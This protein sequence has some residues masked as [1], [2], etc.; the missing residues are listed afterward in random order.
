VAP[1]DASGSVVAPTPRNNSVVSYTWDFGDGGSGSGMTATH[2]CAQAGSYTLKLS[3][4]DKAGRVGTATETVVVET[5]DGDNSG[6]T[7]PVNVT[8]RGADGA[9]L[10]GA[11]V[12]M[13]TATGTTGTAGVAQFAQAPAGNDQVLSVSKAGFITQVL[14]VDLVAGTTPQDIGVRLLAV[15]QTIAIQQAEQAQVLLANSLGASVSV[16]A[17]ALVNAAGAVVT[18][19]I[20]LQLTPWD[21]SGT[22]LLAMP[23]NGQALDRQNNPAEL[24][25]AGM[26]T[27]DFR[28]AGGNK[29]QLGAGKTAD[30]QMDLPYASVNRQ[31]LTIGTPI[32]LWF[33]DESKGLWVEDGQGVVVASNTSPVGLGFKATVSHFST[34]NWDFKFDN[35]GSVTVN[36]VNADT[37]TTACAV[38]ATVTL[39]DGSKLVKSNTLGAT[40]TTV[41]N[42]PSDGSIV[43]ESSTSTGL[44]GT[45][46]SGTSGNVVIT[47]NPPNTGNFVQC[48]LPGNTPV[49]CNVSL[50]GVRPDG[51]ET[52]QTF[53][54]PAEGGTVQT[55]LQA[56]APLSWEG[57]SFRVNADLST[58]R[59]RG[60]ATSAA[61]GPVSIAL[62]PDETVATRVARV[63]C[64]TLATVGFNQTEPLGACDITVRVY[65]NFEQQVYANSLTVAT[66]ASVH[67]PVADGA[68]VSVEAQGVTTGQQRVFSFDS[69]SYDSI[70]NNALYLLRLTRLLD[71]S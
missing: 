53:A 31:A 37:T 49:A 56:T 16:P 52:T 43:W 23:G 3:V 14:S 62:G 2:T 38:V 27:V 67:V 33:F 66:G 35:A 71:V 64:D 21:I 63:Q 54:L 8:V 61:S 13:G 60:F 5:D 15:K 28:D 32:P 36:C 25:S 50:A 34:W 55:G 47:L 1:F 44:L 59:N 39:S 22:D 17:N 65:D 20:T 45:T 42:M 29:L 7:V 19:P 12:N 69:F 10:A 9:L 30:I 58:T 4:K 48:L 51:S 40:H 26:M 68:F 6:T 18:G 70:V 57:E 24:I 11:Q 41:V 46:T